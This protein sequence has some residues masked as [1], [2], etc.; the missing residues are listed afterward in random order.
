[1]T[2]LIFSVAILA[3]VLFVVMYLTLLERKFAGRLQ[4]R[5]GPQRV[6]WPFGYLQP[7]AD[8]VK[9]LVKE[10]VIPEV[11][12]RKAFNLAPVLVVLPVLFVFAVIP[13]G[14]NLVLADLNIGVL[15]VLAI[16]SITL[17][18]IFMAAWGSKNKYAVLS[19][20]RAVNQMISYEVPLVIS[21]LVPVILAESMNLSD[22]VAFQDRAW[23]VFYPV[24]GQL[25]FIVFMVSAMAEAN[26]IPFDI[27]EAESELVA[28]FMVEY[29]GMKFAFFFLA[30]YAHML[31][32]SFLAVILFLGGWQGPWLPAGVW[33]ALKVFM[34]FM[35]ILWIRWSLVRIRLDQILALSWKVLF[36]LSLLV[37]LLAGIWKMW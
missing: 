34:V 30:E 13:F 19:G 16:S 2:A 17:I 3:G 36:P 24:L 37:L 15:F 1:M 32:V 27:T 20:M 21:S 28:G 5:I 22:I 11:A 18:G 29:S 6:G 12:D 8:A 26:R 35:L 31:A 7:V 14:E 23:F 25:A 4:S 9:L 33:L 10:D